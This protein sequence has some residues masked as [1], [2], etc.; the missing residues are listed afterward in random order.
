MKRM[1]VAFIFILLVLILVDTALKLFVFHYFHLLSLPSSKLLRAAFTSAR[2][3]N[4][5]GR[6]LLHANL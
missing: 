1:I 2:G 4:E 5:N 6:S 3:V